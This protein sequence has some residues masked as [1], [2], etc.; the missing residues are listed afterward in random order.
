MTCLLQAPIHEPD[1]VIVPDSDEE[2]YYSL[3]QSDAATSPPSSPPP[4]EKKIVQ[5][6]NSL[7]V[8]L[9]RSLYFKL[10]VYQGLEDYNFRPLVH[11][12]VCL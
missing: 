1:P 9:S 3:N 5:I 6:I 4:E 11:Q 2:M 7:Y 10:I 12:T 8:S